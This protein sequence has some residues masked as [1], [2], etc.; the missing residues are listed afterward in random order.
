MYLSYDTD[1]LVL[2]IHP[3]GE[4]SLSYTLFTREL[5][6]VTAFAQGVRGVSS[7]LRGHLLEGAHVRVRLV[8]GKR[9]WRLTSAEMINDYM[10]TVRR[11]EE[12][13]E[14]MA[15]AHVLL[16]KLLGEE[17]HAD[18]FDF[19]LRGFRSAAQQDFGRNELFGLECLLVSGILMHLGY[20]P[21]SRSLV[22]EGETGGFDRGHCE[23]TFSRRREII[24][25]INGALRASH[26]V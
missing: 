1:A 21:A 25:Q 16:K 14:L 9:E 12:A 2:G 3:R 18:L 17:A 22:P 15:N 7:K 10:R 6:L 24:E 5:G 20:L 19:V 26:L 4:S 13:R 8:R 11:R 23:E